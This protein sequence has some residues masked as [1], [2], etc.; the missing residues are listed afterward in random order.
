MKAEE[1][2]VGDVEAE[3]HTAGSEASTGTDSSLEDFL[4]TEEKLACE[5]DSPFINSTSSVGFSEEFTPCQSQDESAADGSHFGNTASECRLSVKQARSHTEEEQVE[6]ED[7][8]G[9]EGNTASS[10]ASKAPVGDVW[11]IVFEPGVNVRDEK[12]LE[13]RILGQKDIHAMVQ[14]TLEGAWL[15]LAGEPGYILTRRG[16]LELLKKQDVEPTVMT[17]V[18]Y[19]LG[20]SVREDKDVKSR[21]LGR[22][23]LQALAK[24]T[25]EGDWLKLAGEPGYMLTRRGALD[26]LKKID[27]ESTVMTVVYELGVNVREDKDVK[28]RSLGVRPLHA[29]AKGT[30]EGDWLKLAGE[31]GYMLARQGTTAL[32]EMQDV[33]M[34]VVYERRGVNVR[35]AKDLES[36]ILGRKRLHGVVRGTLEGDWLKLAGEPGYILSRRGNTE[37]LRMQDVAPFPC[38]AG[39]LALCSQICSH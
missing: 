37:L 13:S 31:P 27:V 4:E 39:V 10:D 17:V 35:E 2:D 23:P 32:L 16:A 24:G 8:E 33:E 22:R 28:S 11:A 1:K 5:T 3:P 34:T 7:E 26:L 36:R 18:V 9:Q 25:L 14:G 12:N 15:K 19:E 30:W 21:S 6:E 38:L 20:V 29:L